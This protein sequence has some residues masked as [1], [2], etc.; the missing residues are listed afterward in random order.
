MEF[1]CLADADVDDLWSQQ[2][3]T[4]CHMADEKIILQRKSL[5]AFGVASKIL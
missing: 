1:S 2:D 4:T 5:G 3:G